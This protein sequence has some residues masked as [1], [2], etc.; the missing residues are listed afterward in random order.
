VL[1]FH[2]SSRPSAIPPFDVSVHFRGG[3]VNEFYP[4]GDASVA[5]D[6]DRIDAKVQAGVLTSWDGVVLDNYVVGSLR[7]AHVTLGD[8]VPT[9]S[10]SSHVWTTPRQVRSA[11]VVTPAGEGERFLF[12]R[13]V[14]HLDALV[15]T[16]LSPTGVLLRAPQRLHWLRAPS[17]TLARLWL[18]AIRADGTVAF[19]E[20]EPMSIAANSPSR[21]LAR[22]R[23]FDDTDYAAASLGELRRSMKQ[24]LV[25]AGLFDDE[26]EAMLETWKETWFRG[27]GL[28]IFYMVPREWTDY[29]LPLRMSAPSQLTRVLVGRI[30]LARP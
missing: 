2:P 21:E 11:G 20:H 3:I 14:A 29:F 19:R 28:R 8:S 16:T 24:A 5:L 25:A 17:M 26:A 1:Y 15:Q 12:Y 10:T 4:A 9:P 22:L 13:G 6:A 18:V 7:W 27:P 23:L 30:D